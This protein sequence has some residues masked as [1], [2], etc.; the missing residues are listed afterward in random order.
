MSLLRNLWNVSRRQFLERSSVGIG[1][2]ALSTLLDRN[3]IAAETIVSRPHA[4]ARANSSNCSII[5]RG[6]KIAL[7]RTCLIPF[8]EA[9]GS[10]E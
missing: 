4:A 8:G 6:S 2:A 10:Q 1:A 9:N 5:S 3:A 7:I